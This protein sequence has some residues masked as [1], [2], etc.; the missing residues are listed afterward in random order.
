MIKNTLIDEATAIIE[1]PSWLIGPPANTTMLQS[2]L[3]EN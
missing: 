1:F 2:N 3:T